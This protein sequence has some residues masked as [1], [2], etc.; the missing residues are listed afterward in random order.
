[1]LSQTD[2]LNK[3]EEGLMSGQDLILYE[4]NNKTRANPRQGN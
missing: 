4:Y 1:M 2:A 3:E